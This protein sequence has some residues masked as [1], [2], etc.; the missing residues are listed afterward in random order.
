MAH[1]PLESAARRA[2]STDEIPMHYCL[3][4]SEF[5]SWKKSS[6]D[7]MLDSTEDDD[8]LDPLSPLVL[9][10]VRAMARVSWHE[11]L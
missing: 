6:F 5:Y 10:L 4:K 9:L 2:I 7:L 8:E 11:Q 1:S 3:P